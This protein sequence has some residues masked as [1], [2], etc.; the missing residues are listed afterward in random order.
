MMEEWHRL[1]QN[2]KQVPKWFL[3]YQA[4]RYKEI[5]DD[6][7]EYCKCPKCGLMLDVRV[8]L[9]C[10]ICIK[11]ENFQQAEHETLMKMFEVFT[12]LGV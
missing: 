1:H 3:E 5:S 12:P 9:N 4:K 7:H 2:E 8:A 6:W 10:P 11:E